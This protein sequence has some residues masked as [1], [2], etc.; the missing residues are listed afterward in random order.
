ML[1]SLSGEKLICEKWLYTLPVRLHLP[2]WVGTSKHKLANGNLLIENERAKSVIW[3]I[4]KPAVWVL[5]W[6]YVL[7]MQHWCVM[8]ITLQ[9]VLHDTFSDDSL[10]WNMNVLA[11]RFEKI[12]GLVIFA[13]YFYGLF[14]QF[15]VDF[16]F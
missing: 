8:Q 13:M 4:Q 7:A 1:S 6:E 5:P 11:K 9:L 14:A 3:T 16:M 12:V 10:F 15:Y 2:G